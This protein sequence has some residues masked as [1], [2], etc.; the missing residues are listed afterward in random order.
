MANKGKCIIFSAPSGAGKT[1]I[2]H[3]L[4]KSVPDLVFSI[5]AT[6]RRPRGAEENGVDYYFLTEKTFKEKIDTGD[7]VEW[8]EVYKGCYYGTLKSEVERIWSEGKHVVFDVDVVGGKNLKESLG[9]RA[10]AIFIKTPSLEVLRERLK[11]RST[12]STEDL[13]MR[14]SKA[15]KEMRYEKRFD[16]TLVN[17]DLKTA[18]KEAEEMV[19]AFLGS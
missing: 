8:E 16:R 14:I 4:L 7:F 13:E 5:S 15:K 12:E 1:T 11:N 18:L 6:T 3:H 2:V 19:K 17:D 10:L 9:D